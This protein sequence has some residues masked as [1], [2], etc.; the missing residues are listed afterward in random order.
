MTTGGTIELTWLGQ[1]GFRVADGDERVLI[2]PFLSARTD[3]RYKPP[4]TAA[5]LADTTVVLC[6]HEH[7]DHLDL[8]FLR[9][10]AERGARPP[11][12]LPAPVV[13]L[14]VDGGLDPAQLHGA[15]PGAGLR[16]GA[17]RVEPVAAWHGVG[18][19][20]GAGYGFRADGDPADRFR[21]LGY[22]VEV[23]G[24]RLFHAGDGLIYPGL[25]E[26]LRGLAPDVLLLPIN[27]HDY[28]RDEFGWPGNMNED[29]AAWLCAQVRPSWV[30]PMHYDGFANNLGDVG[31][32]AG[33]L[34]DGG[35]ASL[36]VPARGRRVRFAL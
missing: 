5:D 6:T 7:D 21:F 4:L 36:L 16:L 34:G 11:V 23:G 31:R 12:V 22:A 32:F 17:V 15:E 20:R 8:A 28:M 25:V 33:A 10:L 29:E 2:D 3:R 1:S 9:E 26:A 19:D 35:P 18:G 14:A 30:I 24:V 27:G 13:P